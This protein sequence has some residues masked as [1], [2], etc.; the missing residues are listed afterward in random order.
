[1]KNIPDDTM[2]SLNEKEKDDKCEEGVRKKGEKKKEN[3]VQCKC[4]HHPTKGT[5]TNAHDQMKLYKVEGV[6]RGS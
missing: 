4:T 2:I 6:A 1:M 5:K 3:P